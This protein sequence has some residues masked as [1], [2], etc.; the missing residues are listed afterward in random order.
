MALLTFTETIIILFLCG[1]YLMRLIMHLIVL[2]FRVSSELFGGGGWVG[3]HKSP[4]CNN[5]FSTL[6]DKHVIVVELGINR[7]TKH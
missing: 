7:H 5:T 1:R 3:S 4:L 6:L 2:L